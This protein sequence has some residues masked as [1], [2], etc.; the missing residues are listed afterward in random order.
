[1]KILVNGREAVLK[2]NASFEYVSENPLFTEAEDYT[3]E[4]P[5]P[6]KDCPQNISIFGP[7]HVKGVDISKVS[8]PCEIQTDAFVKSGILTI[9]SVS[10]TEVK[11]QFLEGM[12]QQNFSSSLPDVYL[13]DLD[14]S[15]WDGTVGGWENYENS[16]EFGWD[17]L[18]VY[19]KE[20][21]E[22]LSGR[23]IY[24][25]HLIKLVA[26]AVGWNVDMSSLESI[27]MFKYILVANRRMETKWKWPKD[28]VR[29]L[30]LSLPY[31]TVKEFFHQIEL[32]FGCVCVLSDSAKTVT[33]R[34][35]SN[36]L[37]ESSVYPIDVTDDFSVELTETE[38]QASYRGNKGWKFPDECN[39]D[40]INA[41]QEFLNDPKY[42]KLIKSLTLQE[43]YDIVYRASRGK[44]TMPSFIDQN[45][46]GLPTTLIYYLPE[47]DEYA[48]VS[49]IEDVFVK[50]DEATSEAEHRF[51]LVDVINQY[52]TLGEGEELGIAPCPIGHHIANTDKAVE[53]VVS[54]I[55]YDFTGKYPMTQLEI[56]EP[57]TQAFFWSSGVIG[58]V[59]AR[60][61]CFL[62]GTLSASFE[63]LNWGKIWQDGGVA[64]RQVMY[65]MQILIDGKV[66]MSATYGA[67]LS[68]TSISGQQRL[69]LQ[70]VGDYPRILDTE[71]EI[72]QL[73]EHTIYARVR[74]VGKNFRES[75]DIS[76][77]IWF[78]DVASRGKIIGAGVVDRSP[79]LTIPVDPEEEISVGYNGV[80]Y[81]EPKTALERIGEA[82]VE[83]K[84]KY[85]KNLW[86]VLY[87][88]QE[89]ETKKFAYT[90]KYEQAVY[91][92]PVSDREGGWLMEDDKV[93]VY[94]FSAPFLQY[95]YTLTPADPS[96]KALSVLPKV[97]ETKLYRYKFLAKTLPSPTS[98]FLIKGKRYA[99]LKLTAQITVKGMS[100]LVEGEFYEIID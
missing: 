36:M 35:C 19:D 78:E 99:C 93:K 65:D 17:E 32:F 50:R 97:K 44:A 9:T 33:F 12:S 95:P 11:G 67:H 37:T 80:G 51:Q 70:Q 57:G 49:A 1:M 7:L 91:T 86:I 5:F 58:K 77:Q 66:V 59:P 88:S 94:P 92:V 13:T 48:L 74:C 98:V 21:D 64:G 75:A 71:F 47:F 14:F 79:I 43:I 25:S 31:W 27:P 68:L 100:E 4:I 10:D 28:P 38:E 72:D 8:F 40:K 63:G 52:R 3:M 61:E 84:D 15:Q 46:Y 29:S 96:I 73:S 42:S 41:C 90:K 54:P 18:V 76:C 20:R 69:E 82:K 26:Q 56:I 2:A 30:A 62:S 89:G 60:E 55:P 23:H 6:M 45:L 16:P 81:F 34:P 85:F 22:Y 24:L 39:P 83:E 53:S 87:S